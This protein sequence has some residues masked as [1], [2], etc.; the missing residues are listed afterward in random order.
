MDYKGFQD[1]SIAAE[2][3]DFLFRQAFNGHIMVYRKEDGRAVMHIN[4]TVRFSPKE[5]HE[6]ANRFQS[7]NDVSPAADARRQNLK[8]N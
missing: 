5:L 4:R 2:T 1:H 7:I 6:F 3:N 8:Y